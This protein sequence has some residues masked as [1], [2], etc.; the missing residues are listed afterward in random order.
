MPTLHAFR[1]G[2]VGR[3]GE[4]QDHSVV[5]QQASEPMSSIKADRGR[6][7]CGLI[8]HRVPNS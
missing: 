3:G 2:S 8:G 6:Y 1:S 4:M 7:S 5:A